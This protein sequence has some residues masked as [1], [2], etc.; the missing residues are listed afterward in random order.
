MMMKKCEYEKCNN[1]F[2]ETSRNKGFCCRECYLKDYALKHKEEMAQTKIKCKQKNPEKYKT[3]NKRWKIDN[4]EHIKE[5]SAQN[6]IKNKDKEIKRCVAY[7]KKRYNTNPEYKAVVL[8]RNRQHKAIKRITKE[9]NLQ[10]YTKKRTKNVLG[11]TDKQFIKY[12]ENQFRPGMTWEN[13][14]KIWEQD[15]IVPVSKIYNSKLEPEDRVSYINFIFH[16]TNLQPLFK[17][18][19][20]E[21]SNKLQ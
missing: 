6:Y 3:T 16:Y 13:Q 2:E 1:E 21:K 12:I 18:E 4:A 17:K 10:K 9:L 8:Y 11:C 15:H 14:G 5:Q 19:N 20:R 7:Q